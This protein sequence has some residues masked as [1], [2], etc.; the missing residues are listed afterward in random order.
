MYSEHLQAY[1]KGSKHLHA[2]FK[3]KPKPSNLISENWSISF[4]LI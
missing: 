1:C 2:Y 4:K 3:K